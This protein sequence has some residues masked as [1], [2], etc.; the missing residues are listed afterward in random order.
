MGVT[1]SRKL[2]LVFLYISIILI[3]VIMFIPIVWMA[4]TSIKTDA[5]VFTRPIRWVPRVPTLNN[6]ITLIRT[7]KYSIFFVNSWIIATCVMV[8]TVT[9]ASFAGYG[10]ARFKFP[11]SELFS[12]SILL[13]QMLPPILLVIPYFMIMKSIR[14]Y[15]TY[16]GVI[17]IDSAYST[18]FCI[19]MLRGYFATIP[20]ELDEAA[21]IDGC[22]HWSTFFKVALPLTIPGLIGT[23]IFSFLW[24]W[25][26]FLFV[27]ILTRSDQL[28][29]VTVGAAALVGQYAIDWNLLMA[30]ALLANLPLLVAFI[31]LQQHLVRGLTGGALKG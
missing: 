12:T 20:K 25:S 1:K 17:L 9:L 19:W 18:P 30:L 31:F 21:L 5:E 23:A 14:L 11:G 6:F 15:N 24:G 4:S 10:L 27:F 8:I 7:P 3:T 16:W 29:T 22:S 13:S 28:K 2:K 26:E